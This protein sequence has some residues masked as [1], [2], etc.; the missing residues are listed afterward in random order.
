MFVKLLFK[1][2]FWI[3]L[4]SFTKIKSQDKVLFQANYISQ[5]VIKTKRIN[6]YS[7]IYTEDNKDN[8]KYYRIKQD[9]CFSQTISKEKKYPK[10][11]FFTDST[12][13]PSPSEGLELKYKNVKVGECWESLLSN[14]V[15][16]VRLERIEENITYA[17]LLVEKCFVYKVE[18]TEV[19]CDFVDFKFFVDIKR[20]IILKLEFYDYDYYNGERRLVSFFNFND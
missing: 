14:R 9:S 3:F 11:D 6:Y 7:Y 10:Y 15:V 16:E 4:L 20:K 5:S 1:L 2:L 17:N 18:E 13:T 8:R 12:F 19:G